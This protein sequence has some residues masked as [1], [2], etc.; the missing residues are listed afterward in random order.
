MG[1]RVK[2]LESG[3]NIITVYTA[4]LYCINMSSNNLDNSTCL[5]FIAFIIVDDDCISKTKKVF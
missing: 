2:S 4:I 3:L 1:S 5:V